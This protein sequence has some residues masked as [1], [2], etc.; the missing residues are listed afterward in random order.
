MKIALKELRETR[1]WLR[2]IVKAKL[3]SPKKMTGLIDEAHQLCNIFG[4][5]IVTAK[6]LKVR[7][8]APS[9]STNT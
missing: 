2:L 8:S 5:S 9:A 4:A 7:K 3:L 6:G 1:Y